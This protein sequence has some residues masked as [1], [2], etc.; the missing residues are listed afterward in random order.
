MSAWLAP[1][2]ARPGLRAVRP[3]MELES[4]RVTMLAALNGV[5][6]SGYVS[7]GSLLPPTPPLTRDMRLDAAAQLHSEEQAARDV[8]DHVG[9]GGT[10]A[11]D[12]II[13]RGYR[14]SAAA[15]NIASG[16][17]GAERTLAQWL[18]SPSHCRAMLSGLYVHAGI[19]VGVSRSGQFYWTLDLASP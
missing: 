13:A 19:G 7:S 12:R 17:A 6:A 9:N 16:N 8:L 11:F 15:E 1:R 3:S 14:Y 10:S 18:G 5:R 2:I 4:A